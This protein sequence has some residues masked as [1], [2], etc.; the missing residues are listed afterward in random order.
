MRVA[1]VLVAVLGRGAAE[2]SSRLDGVREWR[3]RLVGGMRMVEVGWPPRRHHRADGLLEDGGRV[4]VLDARAGPEP[5][6]S[7]GI[8]VYDGSKCTKHKEMSRARL[9]RMIVMMASR[10][11][12]ERRNKTRPAGGWVSAWREGRRQREGCSAV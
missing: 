7:T 4:H 3:R 6:K 8:V 10:G 9:S 11:V 12:D 5:A 1:V 2:R